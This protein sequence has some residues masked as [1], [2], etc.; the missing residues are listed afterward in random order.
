VSYGALLTK[1]EGLPVYR[2]W[3]GMT[4]PINNVADELGD[5]DAIDD[6]ATDESDRFMRQQGQAV[7]YYDLQGRRLN[8]TPKLSGPYI[9][10][11]NAKSRKVLK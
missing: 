3:D 4:M 1:A 10:T 9:K 11:D 6:I 5:P 8:D 2:S 7:Q